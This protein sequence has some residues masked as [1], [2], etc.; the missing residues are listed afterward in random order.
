[1][2]DGRNIDLRIATLEGEASHQ[3]TAPGYNAPE[4]KGVA[5][6]SESLGLTY[7]DKPAI[8][9]PVWIW[10]IPTY[11]FVGGVAGAS[12][13]L[14]M[15]AQLL[16][17][18]KLRTFDERCRWVGA[19]GG[20]VGSALLVHDLGRK[21]RFLY[22]LRI[23]RASSPMSIGSWVLAIATPLSAGSALLTLGNGWVR[24]L[25]Q[26][27]G[28]GAGIL[29]MPLATYTAVL[30]GNTAV[31]VW[32]ASRRSLPLLFG[33][34]SVASMASVF[35]CMPLGERECAIVHRFGL[36]G[37]VGELAAARAVERDASEIPRVGRPLREGLAGSLW[38]AGKILTVSSL[39]VSLI[40]GRSRTKRTISGTLG[41]LAGLCVRFSVFYAGKV[42]ALDPRAS[43]EQQ[44]ASA[45]VAPT[46]NTQSVTSTPA[47]TIV[48]L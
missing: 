28:I 41:I 6:S 21:M 47:E 44:T 45:T 19:I 35:E 20:G 17:G 42:S 43:F 13:T 31:P 48:P 23:F 10:S 32:L 27:A 22:M 1:M 26:A 36:A 33:A 34:S 40:P 39:A 37:R 12:M 25:G 9:P 2:N 30:I 8:K 46:Y 24:R 29:G 5:R 15:A 16:G 7:Y 11:F 18:P 14:A 38:T 4:N 3:Y